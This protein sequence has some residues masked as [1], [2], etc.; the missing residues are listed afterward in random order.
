MLWQESC[1]LFDLSSSFSALDWS[2]AEFAPSDFGSMTGASKK[3]AA[4]SPPPEDFLL[5][6]RSVLCRVSAPHVLQVTSGAGIQEGQ[7][8]G[9][10]FGAEG[11]PGQDTGEHPGGHPGSGHWD[12]GHWDSGDRD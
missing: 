7:E 10:N 5:G 4:P 8:G 11:D 2:R 9:A 3:K 6:L 1:K 12:S